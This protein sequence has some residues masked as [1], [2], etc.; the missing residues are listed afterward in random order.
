MPLPLPS[1]SQSQYRPP[2][3]MVQHA[4]EWQAA[5]GM[6]PQVLQHVG[7]PV[8]P[9]LHMGVPGQSCCPTPQMGAASSWDQG[10]VGGPLAAEQAWQGAIPA[11]GRPGAGM[12]PPLPPTPPPPLP[13]PPP[14]PLGQPCCRLPPIV[15][16][17]ITH[18]A[19]DWRGA[20]DGMLAA[21]W[22]VP[23]SAQG[24]GP[25]PPAPPCWPSPSGQAYQVSGW[26]PLPPPLAPPECWTSRGAPGAI[27]HHQYAAD[28]RPLQPLG[29]VAWQM[30][31]PG[32]PP[33]F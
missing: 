1:G 33:Y 18:V 15:L 27:H 29:L 12:Q 26:E 10:H 19:P 17:G 7:P 8:Q 22:G 13:T 14:P 28:W 11:P 5:N 16:S 20:S 30:P 4:M 31:P 9:L 23:Q 21:S 6:F 3:A 32:P 24:P 2:Q 25:L